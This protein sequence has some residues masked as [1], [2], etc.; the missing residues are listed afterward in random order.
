L[1]RSSSRTDAVLI[2]NKPHIQSRSGR[3]EEILPAAFSF[4]PGL[5][6]WGALVTKGAVLFAPEKNSFTGGPVSYMGTGST[7]AV[8]SLSPGSYR[9]SM[10]NADGWISGETGAFQVI[11]VL[12]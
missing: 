7:F 12:Y 4:I 6:W 10:E 11:I 9:F 2:K 8:P 1:E 5:I 3:G